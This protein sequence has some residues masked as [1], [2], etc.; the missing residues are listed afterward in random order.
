MNTSLRQLLFVGGI[1]G[2]MLAGA[3][4]AIVNALVTKA[5]EG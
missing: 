4:L 1:V 5:K 3:T 2:G